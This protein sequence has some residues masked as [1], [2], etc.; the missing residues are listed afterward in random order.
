MMLKL[1]K[2]LWPAEQLA[3]AFETLG[4]SAQI[5]AE[6]VSLQQFILLTKILAPK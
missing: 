6:K 3:A 1:L 2:Q 4:L 5:R